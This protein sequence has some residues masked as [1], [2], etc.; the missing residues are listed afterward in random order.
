MPYA[1]R[2]S[3]REGAAQGSPT[4]PGVSEGCGTL[5]SEHMLPARASPSSCTFLLRV[6]IARLQAWQ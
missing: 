5:H 3:S 1:A 4:T 6:T 2:I